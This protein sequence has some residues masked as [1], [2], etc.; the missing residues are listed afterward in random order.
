[1]VEEYDLGTFHKMSTA[2]PEVEDMYVLRALVLVLQRCPHM[3]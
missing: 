3:L 2:V 1:M